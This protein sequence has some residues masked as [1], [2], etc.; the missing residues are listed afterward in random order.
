MP[1]EIDWP[2]NKKTLSENY[3]DNSH[4]NRVTCSYIEQKGLSYQIAHFG[5]V[6][7]D[8]NVIPDIANTNRLINEADTIEVNTG[9][10]LLQNDNLYNN[11]IGQSV[12]ICESLS[13]NYL[14]EQDGSNI[15]Q[16]FLLPH[17]KYIQHWNNN[18]SDN[19]I[20]NHVIV[21]SYNTG[22]DKTS[23]WILGAIELDIPSNKAIIK[24]YDP[25]NKVGTS[26]KD[27][28]VNSNIVSKISEQLH[29]IYPG[30]L[31]ENPGYKV[32]RR[33]QYDIVSC[34]VISAVN[35][36][37]VIDG[38]L[39]ERLKIEYHNKEGKLGYQF[40]QDMRIE[41]KRLV[42][43]YQSIERQHKLINSGNI[44][45]LNLL[46]QLQ[47]YNNIEYAQKTEKLFKEFTSKLPKL[48]EMLESESIKLQYP[49]LANGK[50]N[51]I[52]ENFQT[53]I[54]NKNIVENTW[55][56]ILQSIKNNEISELDLSC[57]NTKISRH[58]FD[59]PT[60]TDGKVKELSKL[61]QEYISVNL[62]ELGGVL[63]ENT[64]LIKINISNNKLISD[65]MQDDPSKSD[66]HRAM[67]K[68][69]RDTRLNS[70]I[71]NVM[72]HLVDKEQFQT[73]N[74]TDNNFNIEEQVKLQEIDQKINLMFEP[75]KI[76]VLKEIVTEDVI[77][78]L[79]EIG[80]IIKQS[81]KD[82]LK[83]DRDSFIQKFVS[84][85]SL[86]GKLIALKI[87]DKEVIQKEVGK[88]YDKMCTKSGVK[89][90]IDAMQDFFK[91]II[92]LLTKGTK[93]DKV[94]NILKQ[95]ESKITPI[96]IGKKY[97]IS[98]TI[99]VMSQDIIPQSISKNQAVRL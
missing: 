42:E 93:Y 7:E 11:S 52:Y 10:V 70:I 56:K 47:D 13:E 14:L 75:N 76:F 71:K 40:C 97:S 18:H 24:C 72:Q 58:I 9:N 59:D 12:S 62:D 44:E 46:Q 91:N 39:D 20:Q 37:G 27:T 51:E 63:K 4:I 68:K 26:S 35:A 50:I 89:T 95:S 81:N 61:L 57:Q 67:V 87:E 33:Q 55:K 1:V 34:G 41:D 74:F 5:D 29:K 84:P 17:L 45:E 98:K 92:S 79:E 8:T 36:R 53:I 73:I 23:H 19:H 78:F 80:D 15:L 99:S 82:R 48:K 86:P 3:Y 49:Q 43:Q 2:I 65:Q 30:M 64:S 94:A 32:E 25:M 83:L 77:K 85:E 31:L 88:I 96:L 16:Q 60:F 38:N 66:S 21:F 28:E 6:I 69:D 22:E 54:E 90:V